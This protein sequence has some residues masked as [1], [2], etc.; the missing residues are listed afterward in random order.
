MKT[1]FLVFSNPLDGKE[2]EYN[3][4]YTNVHLKEV[5]AIEGFKSA[6]RF[7]LTKE[8][9]NANQ[10]HKY[11]AI[12]EIE[13]QD[14]EG[15]L[16]SLQTASIKMKMEPVIDLKNVKISIFQSITDIIK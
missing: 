9:Q 7:V 4:W 12:Y 10:P 13:N 11:L 6:Q 3:D 16:Q 1:Y 14:I 2:D 5:V 8:Q 15:T